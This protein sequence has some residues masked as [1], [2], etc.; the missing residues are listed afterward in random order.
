MRQPLHLQLYLD[1]EVAHYRDTESISKRADWSLVRGVFLQSHDRTWVAGRGAG[2][3]RVS[4]CRPSN[5][6]E[7]G[8]GLCRGEMWEASDLPFGDGKHQR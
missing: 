7:A 3:R 4:T 6:R 2:S 1:I 8:I 5:G